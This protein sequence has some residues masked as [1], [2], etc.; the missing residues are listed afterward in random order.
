MQRLAA[1]GAT[2]LTRVGGSDEARSVLLTRLTI[3]TTVL[4]AWELLARSGLLYRDVVPPLPLIAREFVLLF[5]D[6][7]FYWNL[8]VTVGEVLLAVAERQRRN[9]SV[10]APGSLASAKLLLLQ[11]RS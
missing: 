7:S 10:V 2:Q 11:Q 5:V 8:G 1:L 9:W 4:V 3:L 6:P